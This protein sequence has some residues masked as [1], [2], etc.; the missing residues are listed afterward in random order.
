MIKGSAVLIDSMK[1]TAEGEEKENRG[2]N[3]L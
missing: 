1:E 3:H 2:Y